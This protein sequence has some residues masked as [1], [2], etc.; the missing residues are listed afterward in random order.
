MGRCC[1]I[2][3]ELVKM[4]YTPSGMASVTTSVEIDRVSMVRRESH[5]RVFSGE[6]RCGYWE[7]NRER[8]L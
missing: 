3:R 4:M 2:I 1:A 7:L 6:R 8:R 5:L